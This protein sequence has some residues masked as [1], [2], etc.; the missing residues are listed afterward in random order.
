MAMPLMLSA[1]RGCTRPRRRRHRAHSISSSHS[2]LFPRVFVNAKLF[3][4]TQR[5]SQRP[6]QSHSESQH[7]REQDSSPPPVGS[8]ARFFRGDNSANKFRQQ[9][10]SGFF[11]FILVLS[12]WPCWG[13]MGRYVRGAGSG[14]CAFFPGPLWGGAIWGVFA[15]GS[16]G[17]TFFLSCRLCLLRWRR[18]ALV[19]TPWLGLHRDAVCFCVGR[20]HTD[21]GRAVLRGACSW[22]VCARGCGALFLLLRGRSRC[23]GLRTIVLSLSVHN[24]RH[25]ALVMG[26]GRGAFCD[27]VCVRRAPPL[28]FHGDTVACCLRIVFGMWW[29]IACSLVSPLAPILDTRRW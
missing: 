1:C 17:A 20:G 13:A 14:E 22:D 21:L 29:K 15:C 25:A 26:L 4:S 10:G 27:L 23:W 2:R 18:S 6:R 12:S 9:D 19:T 3:P 16:G 5:P 24:L 7:K 11:F 28:H 8:G